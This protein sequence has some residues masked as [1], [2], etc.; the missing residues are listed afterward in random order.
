MYKK[1]ILLTTTVATFFL[2]S[3]FISASTKNC[4][5]E[6]IKN[7]SELINS[8][9]KDFDAGKITEEEINSKYPKIFEVVTVGGQA[10]HYRFLMDVNSAKISIL[11]RPCI[12]S[13]YTD[14]E[15]LWSIKILKLRGIKLDCSFILEHPSYPNSQTGV[16]EVLDS[17]IED[18][19]F[20]MPDNTTYN[21]LK[22]Q[23]ESG[24]SEQLGIDYVIDTENSCQLFTTVGKSWA[25]MMYDKFPHGEPNA[26]AVISPELDFPSLGPIYFNEDV[27]PE[28]SLTSTSVDGGVF[29][30]NISEG[31]YT[32]TA[33]KE[34][35]NFDTVKIKARPG[36]LLNA[37]PPHGVQGDQ[38]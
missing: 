16:I 24:I 33:E 17:D 13:V 36:I 25:S 15:G 38:D 31:T 14:E 22:S 29:Y 9:I 8:I 37:A 32:I 4:K 11:E 5:T 23:L 1:I 20:Q 27:V 2:V 7:N 26:T 3:I 6:N 12:K 21:T 28:P 18:I 34:D 30:A 35:V 10:F 19:T